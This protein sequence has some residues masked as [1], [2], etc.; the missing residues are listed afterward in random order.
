MGS[1]PGIGSGEAPDVL[2]SQSSTGFFFGLTT[3]GHFPLAG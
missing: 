2:I 3:S 1:S